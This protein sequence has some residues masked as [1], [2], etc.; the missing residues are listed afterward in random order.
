[1]VALLRRARTDEARRRLTQQADEA[2]S[3]LAPLREQLGQPTLVDDPVDAALAEG[4][5]LIEEWEAA[6]ITVVSFGDAEY[7]ARL[8]GVHD[9]PGVLFAR[10]SLRSDDR[11]IA[12]VG[13][14]RS[15]DA[16]LRTAY[17]L[18][19]R[20][21]ERGVTV[22]SGLASG[23]DTAA[24]RGALA[25]SGRAVGVIGTGLNHTYPPE[26][27]DLHDEVAASGVLLSQF[28]PDTLPDRHTFPARNATMSGYALATVIV[29]AGERSGTRIQA[30]QAVEHGRP[31]L[32][33][34]SVLKSTAWAR[35][36]AAQPDVHVVDGV[37]DAL[38]VVDSIIDRPHR[39]YDLL[40]SLVT[41]L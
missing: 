16:G 17:T 9:M 36:F 39:M 23:I 2:G 5:A 10:G 28:W 38:S 15:S 13:S 33:L 18:G 8:R 41:R 14:R 20:I 22:V 35:K 24:H 25:A 1:M 21:A 6:G 7:P 29:E 37:E 26:N 11:S 30:R 12:V 34:R 3:A 27:R 40:D 19:R 4:A 32:L 31:V